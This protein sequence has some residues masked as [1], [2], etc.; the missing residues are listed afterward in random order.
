MQEYTP[1]VQFPQMAA[2]PS[3]G[4]ATCTTHLVRS[5]LGR[6]GTGAM[7]VSFSAASAAST[8]FPASK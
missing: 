7:N 6:S 1:L 4:V 8:D 2:A 5:G 3:R